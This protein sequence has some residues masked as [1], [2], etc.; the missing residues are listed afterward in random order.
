MTAYSATLIQCAMRLRR[1]L[2]DLDTI[3]PSQL[4]NRIHITWMPIQMNDHYS[5]GPACNRT[6][7]QRHIYCAG[8]P[9]RFNRDGACP[10][11]AHS[12]PR[13]NICVSRHD[14]LISSTNPPSP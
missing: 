10:G 5:F 12:E 1:I 8:V 11:M 9:L 3:F 14:Y 7:N 13:C 2:H 4:Y 6:L